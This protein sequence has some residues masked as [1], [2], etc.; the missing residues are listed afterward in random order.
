VQGTGFNVPL[1]DTVLLRD[2]GEKLSYRPTSSHRCSHGRQL[3]T[4]AAGTQIA[5][6]CEIQ[7]KLKWAVAIVQ[8]SP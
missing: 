5:D 6:L 4:H 8:M 1:D 3:T 2:A 7:P